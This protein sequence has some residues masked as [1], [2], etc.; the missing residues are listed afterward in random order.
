MFVL[1]RKITKLVLC[2]RDRLIQPSR[3][4]NPKL[5][6]F[7]AIIILSSCVSTK[8]N[9]YQ[10]A[11]EYYES[12]NYAAAAAVIEKHKDKSYKEKDKVLF[13]LDTGMLYHY[14]GEYE[15]SNKAL[16]TAE[17]AIEELFTKSIS[18][19]L[20]SYVLN[21]NIK[22]YS[23]EDYEDI[24]IN[25]FKALNY[26]A[27]G[28]KDS[29]LV[30]IRRVNI[31]L[32]ILEDK[33]RELIKDYNSSE[34]PKGKIKA[35][36]NRF[37]NDALS[38]YL[39]L[40]LYKADNSYDDARIEGNEINKA[41]KFQSHLY[42]FPKPEI[43]SPRKETKNA[44][45]SIIAFTG[46]SPRKTAETFYLRTTE[47]MV[48][49]AATSQDEEYVK[50]IAGFTAL[51]MPGVAGGYH[52][53]FQYPKMRMMGTS[54]N[55]IELELDGKV[56]KELELIEDMGKISKEI[57]LIKQPLLTGKAILRTVGK[58]ILKEQAKT[59]LGTRKNGFLGGLMGIAADLAVDATENADLRICP[60]FPARAS[61]TNLAIS[62]GEHNVS[63]IYYSENSHVF[64]DD[65]GLINISKNKLNIIESFCNQ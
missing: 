37:H 60:Y 31:K 9:Q 24:Y 63:I 45:L 32:N 38:R 42:N 44:S 17:Q 7:L 36:K 8:Q 5:L 29:A 26:I 11:A 25:I 39:G 20:A 46:K 2:I 16:S 19:A 21:D 13:Y 22:D 34:D 1:Y 52:F 49:I 61:V 12:G 18:K 4:Y 53:K 48:W 64:R 10:E 65:K 50:E 58:N 15:K 28:Q 55:R 35:I 51:P 59:E 14:A 41:F 47:N 6:T 23:G 33:Y 43:P 54:I 27:L 3:R 56:V 57:Y 40:L 62:P 30:E